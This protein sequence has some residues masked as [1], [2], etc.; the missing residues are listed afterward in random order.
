MA[1]TTPQRKA[2]WSGPVALAS[3]AIMALSTRDAWA[4]EPVGT[5]LLG[6]MGS[7]MVWAPHVISRGT[8][9]ASL[10][11]DN[12]HLRTFEVGY[13]ET[14]PLGEYQRQRF[15]AAFAIGL[16][17]GLELA[18]AMPFERIAAGPFPNRSFVINGRTFTEVGRETAVGDARVS[19]RWQAWRSGAEDKVV[20]L[21][22]LAEIPTN[23]NNEGISTGRLG[24]GAGVGFEV[25]NFLGTIDVVRPGF[26]RKATQEAEL[27]VAA[28]Y[29]VPI[30]PRLDWISEGQTRLFLEATEPHSEIFR[31]G[32]GLRVWLA[33]GKVAV[34]GS[35]QLEWL[36]VGANRV[37]PG[38]TFS[39]SR[40]P[41][42]FGIP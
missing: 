28:A 9:A 19:I 10:A 20:G 23:N 15:W 36:G 1:L 14:G 40:F 41:A 30:G 6:E 37:S 8:W 34:T 26:L 38:M 25:Q 5:T 27:V 13:E 32:S 22:A 35:L 42:H 7:S 3:I 12:A 31:L 16:G 21:R 18:F 17:S 4:G 11:F 39:V 33:R 29:R 2:M 24:V